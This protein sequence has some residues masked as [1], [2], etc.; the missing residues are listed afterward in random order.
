M[1]LLEPPNTARGIPP[2]TILPRQV[3][4]GLILYSFCA[5]PLLARNPHITSSK[6][7]R[8][9][10]AFVTS[11]KVS[12]NP[13]TGGTQPILPATGSTIIHAIVSPI[14]SNNCVTASIS[15]YGNVMVFS[16]TPFGTPGLSGTPNVARPEPAFTNRESL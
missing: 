9:P 1:I 6:I 2:P 4:S 14:S 7:N 11:R 13:S 16:A 15:L 3:K 8:A 12:R 5:P 10:C